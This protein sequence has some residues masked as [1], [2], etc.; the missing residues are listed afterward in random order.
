MY[1]NHSSS[2]TKRILTR[3]SRM[4][5]VRNTTGSQQFGSLISSLNTLNNNTNNC[6]NN[7]LFTGKRVTIGNKISELNNRP[8][9][10]V[11][12]LGLDDNNCLSCSNGKLTIKTTFSSAGKNL[13]TITT[14]FD[15]Y[16]DESSKEWKVK[17]PFTFFA[18]TFQ[19]D[20]KF[21]NYQIPCNN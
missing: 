7:L 11:G 20:G 3:A 18:S 9:F 8:L 1:K 4:R 15:Y 2:P 6:I 13:N 14:I 19:L 10:P 16:L 21:E 17:G 12:P 5:Q